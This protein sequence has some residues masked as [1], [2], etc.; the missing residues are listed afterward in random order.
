MIALNI[1]HAFVIEP[2]NSLPPVSLSP[3]DFFAF[4]DDK[5][6]AASR[7]SPRREG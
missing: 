7:F 5:K 6:P 2:A 4:D 3:T 1:D